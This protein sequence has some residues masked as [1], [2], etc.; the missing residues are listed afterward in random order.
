MA[1]QSQVTSNYIKQWISYAH[2]D[3]PVKFMAVQEYY[4]V[5][6]LNLWSKI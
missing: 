1:I 4:P 5:L 3:W 6:S 2:K